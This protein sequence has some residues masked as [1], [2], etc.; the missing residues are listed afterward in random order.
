MD[1]MRA[2]GRE[3][4]ADQYM[5]RAEQY[6]AMYLKRT[7]IDPATGEKVKNKTAKAERMKNIQC[8]YCQALGHTRRTCE[9]VKSDKLVFVE[10]SR[11]ARVAA[12]ETAKQTGI[13]VGSLIPMRIYGYHGADGEQSYGYHLSLRYVKGVDWN[14]V[15]SLKPALYATHIEAGKL[16]SARA[17]AH[18]GRDQIKQMKVSYEE[19]VTYNQSQAVP[20][21][22]PPVSLIPTLDPPAGW[23]E[24]DLH[25]IDVAEYFPTKGGKY[26]KQRDYRYFRPDDEMAQVIRDLG[27][28]EG[29]PS[30]DRS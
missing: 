10:Q 28:E 25:T 8:G 3:D 5:V 4:T 1:R 7:K 30:I 21:D 29:Y 9:T 20:L 14:T 13:G 15:T 16:G 26:D 22:A 27:L 23:L 18:S 2:D 12:L 19:A 17:A 11:R 6:R 24:C